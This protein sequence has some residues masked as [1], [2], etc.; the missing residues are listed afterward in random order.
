M[1]IGRIWIW[2][3]GLALTGAL[4]FW[5]PWPSEAA[6]L[7]PIA[8]VCL[9]GLVAAMAELVVAVRSGEATTRRSYPADAE[10]A[11]GRVGLA[12][13]VG[14]LGE[15]NPVDPRFHHFLTLDEVSRL[16]PLGRGA[17]VLWGRVVLF[18]L[19]VGRDGRGW[20]SEEIAEAHKSLIRAGEWIEREAIRWGA[21]VNIELADTVFVAEDN[22]VEDV[23]IGFVPE[24]DEQG[25]LEALALENALASASKAA[26]RLGFADVA[27]LIERIGAR[28]E[29]DGRVWLVH[30]RRAG[31]SIAALEQD[32]GLPGVNLAVC[33]ARETGFSEP[34]VGP[35]FADPVTFV[36]ELM[37]LFGAEDKY[38]VSL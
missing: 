35:P 31:R 17:P 1:R 19:F 3:I 8:L 11:D 14:V 36:H 25:P 29:A 9:V 16:I 26:A 37:H 32:S 12:K 21:A 18:S 22:L 10:P 5:I 30:L 4:A 20:S 27:D 7:G 24:G 6:G 28:V 34:L 38:S 23:E 2:L 15:P 33:Y 13:V